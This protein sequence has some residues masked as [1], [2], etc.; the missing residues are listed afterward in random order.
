MSPATIDQ[1]PADSD[2]QTPYP[3]VRTFVYQA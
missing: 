2:P 1:A 3:L